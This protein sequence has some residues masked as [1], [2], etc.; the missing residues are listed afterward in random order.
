MEL[1]FSH[2]GINRDL[3]QTGHTELQHEVVQLSERCP[4]FD[5]PWWN[6]MKAYICFNSGMHRTWWGWFGVVWSVDDPGWDRELA[7]HVEKPSEAGSGHPL[8]TCTAEMKGCLVLEQQHQTTASSCIL[9]PIPHSPSISFSLSLSWLSPQYDIVL[10]LHVY[11][12]A[13][14]TLCRRC[15][16]E[17]TQGGIHRSPE[18]SSPPIYVFSAA[19]W[20]ICFP[21]VQFSV[22]TNNLQHTGDGGSVSAPQSETIYC[23]TIFPKPQEVLLIFSCL[24]VKMPHAQQ[25]AKLRRQTLLHI[26]NIRDSTTLDM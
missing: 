18:F 17:I 19:I 10:P 9:S 26:R 24:S 1:L 5:R 25:R 3:N 22:N 12:V 8:R 2:T 21:A 13:M 6:E 14:V 23:T 16:S 4:I 11:P 20:F 15:H 7:R